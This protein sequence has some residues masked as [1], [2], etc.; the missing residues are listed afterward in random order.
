MKRNPG[1]R[2]FGL[3]PAFDLGLPSSGNLYVSISGK[4]ETAPYRE[5][6]HARKG[7]RTYV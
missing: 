5:Q 2:D 6:K 4:P 3:S 1:K 7:R